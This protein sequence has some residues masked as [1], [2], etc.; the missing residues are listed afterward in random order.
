MDYATLRKEGIRLLERMSGGEWTDFN[1]HD[2]GIT[3][4][5]QLCYVLSDF[6]YRTGH[7]IPDL[8]P[9]RVRRRMPACIRPTRS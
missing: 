4:L 7:A 2:P 1:A 8:W 5:E 9:S 6:A 3:L